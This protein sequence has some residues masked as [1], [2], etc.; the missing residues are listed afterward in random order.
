MIFASKFK[1]FFDQNLDFVLGLTKWL[2]TDNV[3]PSI[4]CGTKRNPRR[5]RRGAPED[6]KCT[7]RIQPLDYVEQLDG[8][9]M[10]P[11]MTV[12]ECQQALRARE[13]RRQGELAM[14]RRRQNLNE[15]ERLITCSRQGCSSH[16]VVDASMYKGPF[17]CSRCAKVT[18]PAG[19]LCVCGR[20]DDEVS[21]R[22][23][24]HIADAE[25]AAP[26]LVKEAARGTVRHS[27][28][29]GSAGSTSSTT[30]SKRKFEASDTD[31]DPLP[32][33]IG[34]RVKRRRARSRSP[35]SQSAVEDAGDAVMTT[36]QPV[37]QPSVQRPFGRRGP[38]QSSH[39]RFT[40][41]DSMEEASQENEGDKPPSEELDD[42]MQ[43]VLR[44]EFSEGRP[45]SLG[46]RDGGDRYDAKECATVQSR[47]LETF[48]LPFHGVDRASISDVSRMTYLATK[49][50]A[51][52]GALAPVWHMLERMEPLAV[53][54][55]RCPKCNAGV[56]VDEEKKCMQMQCEN[57]A[58]KCKFC[59]CCGGA[60]E[61]VEDVH[62]AY[63]ENHYKE[64]QKIEGEDHY[65]AK[66]WGFI[67]LYHKEAPVSVNFLETAGEHWNRSEEDLSKWFEVR[68]ENRRS[69]VHV[70][71]NAQ[72]PLDDAQYWGR[73]VLSPRS[74]N[75]I[76]SELEDVSLGPKLVDELGND[77][78]LS[79]EEKS[80]LPIDQIR[81]G[82]KTLYRKRDVLSQWQRER[83]LRL[84]KEEDAESFLAAIRTEYGQDLLKKIAGD[85]V[86]PATNEPTQRFTPEALVDPDRK[87][88]K[89]NVG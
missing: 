60:L 78:E 12:R 87:L 17:V 19:K 76:A 42:A 77:L 34:A 32:S 28:D 68:E 6:I 58:C 46:L 8:L 65:C 35:S 54:S 52:C 50:H 43:S 23:I 20:G 39:I 71:D 56:V 63:D 16:K 82:G 67:G 22:R 86:D 9:R 10:E 70:K 38:V 81:L 55:V 4:C 30:S 31:E 11:V 33:S 83:A 40:Q 72:A 59:F 37:E 26:R 13:D 75:S 48:H 88:F 89:L 61:D 27:S 49:A 18:C 25:D 36:A 44:P 62:A 14:I 5:R 3:P 84:L 29:T 74:D 66:A 79:E 2:L 69:R 45:D 80:D 41:T 51:D 53:V 73:V 1:F 24:K 85:A 57:Q 47:Y 21:A 64:P 7:R 15:G